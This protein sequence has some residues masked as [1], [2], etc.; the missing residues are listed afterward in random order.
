MARTKFSNLKSPISRL[1]TTVAAVILLLAIAIPVLADGIVIPDPPPEP[2]PPDEMGWLTIRYHRVDVTIED[3]VAITRVEQ[4]F[5]NEYDWE[6][7]GTYIFPLPEGAAVSEFAMWVDGKRV[8]GSILAADEARAIYEDIVRR[9]RDPALLEYVGRGA[10]QA[11][12]FPIPPGGSRKIELEYSQVLPVES[13]LVRYVYPLNTEKF[14]A[15]PLELVS[16]RVEVRSKDAM[17]ALYSPTHQDRLFIERDG[18]YRAVVGYEEYD[19]LPDQDFDLIYTVSHEDVGLNLLT[20]REAG[21]GGSAYGEADGFFLLMVAPTVEVDRVIPRDVILVLD[22]SGSM[23]GEKIAQAKDALAYVLDHLNDEDRFNVIAF[24]TGLQQYARG[25]R[26]ASEAREAIRWVDGLEAVGGTD[27]NRALLEALDQADEERPTVII[28]LTDG[29]P[30]E[31]VVEINQILANVEATA[32]GNVRLFPFGVGDDVNT[33]LLD[34]L[35]EQQRGAAGYVR[36]HER[37]DEEVSGFYS[38]ISTP[39]LADIALDFGDVLVEDTY[40]YPLPDL[41]AGTQLILV[42]RY[43]DSGA[44]KITLT[45]EVDGE[46]QKFVYEGTFRGS[47]GGGDASVRF[48]PRLW[49]TRKIGYLLKQ[50]RLHGEREEWIDAIVELSVRYGVITPYTSFLIDEDDILTEEGRDEAK[51]DYAATPAPQAVGAPA[52]DRAEKEGDLYDSESVGGGEALPEEAAQVVRLVGSKTFL[53]RDGVWIDTAFDPSKMT[54]VKVDFG[55]DGYFDLLAARPEWGAYFALGSR[56]VFIAEGTAYEIVEAGGGPV[57]IPPTH[58]P[59]PTRSAPDNPTP[60]SGQD[61]PTTTPLA[62]SGKSTTA[63]SRATLCAGAI[64][65]V[66]GAVVALLVLVRVLRR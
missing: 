14:S 11:R 52:A 50:I 63:P 29:L 8:E 9:R 27:I 36:P 61:Q 43:R 54:T 39:V 13:G 57:E 3:Q 34:T 31:G 17:R 4:E 12:I 28:F 6:A 20:Y 26:P 59:D 65:V 49:A 30:T 47:G 35:A 44:T 62:G 53:L 5:V 45:G 15:R 7:E 10:V 1:A 58:A 60:D 21:E 40:H 25:L 56:V 2:M 48:I 22:V 37:I 38:K 42:G 23:D 24:S 18:D 51:D 55:S 66:A 33:L 46:T 19:V 32:P 41:F 64:V 16:V